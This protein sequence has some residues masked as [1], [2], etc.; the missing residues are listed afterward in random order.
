MKVKIYSKSFFLLLLLNSCFYSKVYAQCSG[1]GSETLGLFYSLDDCTNPFNT[2][3]TGAFPTTVSPPN[4]TSCNLTWDQFNS[5][6]GTN[7]FFSCTASYP[8]GIGAEN[9]TTGMCTQGYDGP[10]FCGDPTVSNNC[11]SGFF[12]RVIGSSTQPAQV[13]RLTFYVKGY[14]GQSSRAS[15]KLGVKITALGS[16]SNI[17]YLQTEISVHPN[18]WQQ[19]SID[20]SSVPQ[21]TI[22]TTLG[23]FDIF[24]QGYAPINVPLG[25]GF[26]PDNRPM[27]ELDQI[28]I[29]YTCAAAPPNATCAATNTTNCAFP[30]GTASVT[31]NAASASYSWSNGGTTSTINNL[32]AGTYT[33]TVTNTSTGCTNTCQA[34]VVSTTNLPTATCS[35][36]DNTNCATPNGSASVTTNGN[37]ISW[38]T[39][40]TTASITGLSAGTYTVTV[41]NTTTGCTNTCQAIVGSTASP[42]T[43]T[44]SKTNNTNCVTPNGTAV[45]TATGVS[46]LWSNG[47]TTATITGL[48]NA[49]YTVTVTSTTTGCTATCSAIVINAPT[50]P[51]ATCSKVDNTNC[52]TPN[53]SASVTT[54]GNQISWSTGSTFAAINGLSAGT[55]TVTVTNTA[56]G[57]TN[58]CQ[59][60]VTNNTTNPT[61]TCGK[62]DNTNCT[63]PNGTATAAATGVTYVWSNNA[64]TATISGL[65]AGAYTVTVTS[66]TTGC[67][68]TCS[69]VVGTTTTLPTASCTPTANTNCATPNGSATVTTNA[70]QILWSTGATT[71]TITGLA[72]GTYTVTVTNTTTGCTNTCQAV[73][74]NNTV[75]PTCTI[76]PNSQPSCANLTGGSVTVT[77]SPAGTYSYV[78][79]DSGTA[80]ANRTGLTGGTYTVT[81]TN[82]TT[83]CS[84]NCNITLDTPMNCCNI[85]AITAINLECLDNGTPNIITDNMIRFSA[86]VTNANQTL[87]G[88]NVIINGGTTIMSNTNIPYGLTQF[89]LGTGTA[90]GGA[91]FTVTVTD[92]TT[93][94]CTQTFQVTDPGTCNNSNPND[95]LTPKCGTATIQVNG[96]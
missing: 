76:A 24:W 53:G 14:T 16:F 27:I 71:A 68:A 26:Q 56:T 47:G 15:S 48:S 1:S 42:P 85:N 82:T 23:G 13:S 79:S 59:A 75:N 25:A 32:S 86:Q 57:C 80:T 73:V 5:F 2:G 28:R 54:N 95:C 65:S 78:W 83:G 66:T 38:S 46:Y 21:L 12:L 67:T 7:N 88:Y 81:V 89:T 10:N 51:T 64:T 62:T 93:S 84:G 61:V 35:K 63:N 60:V 55:Y 40:A 44:C 6:A 31:T 3:Y 11:Y 91:T 37:Q 8:G 29:Y 19:V 20:L 34:V 90:G 17:Y 69:A 18:N 33:V 52:A 49:T 9:S 77:P 22:G 58:T 50:L 43:V 72:V 30:N 4:A 70:N 92:I 94:G 45:A 96:N 39:G 36:M 87:T 41:T 74:G